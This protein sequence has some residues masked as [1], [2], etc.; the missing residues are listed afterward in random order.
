M[1]RGTNPGAQMLG[2]GWEDFAGVCVWGGW[3]MGRVGL[4]SGTV[5]VTFLR[6]HTGR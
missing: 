3:G 1:R 5:R 4:D 2:L 6:S